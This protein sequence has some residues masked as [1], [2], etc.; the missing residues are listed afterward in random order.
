MKILAKT[1]SI[2]HEEWLKYRTQGIGGSDVSVIAGINPFKSVYQLWLE[3]IGQ[4]DIEEDDTEYTHFGR[5]L[6][7]I[8]RKEFINRTGMKVRQ[9]HMILQSEEYPF[10]IANLDGTIN[11]N[12]E[13]AIFEA[14]AVSAFKQEIWEVGIPSSYILQIQ[15]YMAVTGAKKAYIA[16]IVG[17]NHFYYHM[18]ERD[19]EMIEKIILMEKYFWE[20]NVLKGIE[21]VLDGSEATTN[22]IN[23]KFNHSN[24]ETII[25]PEEAIF[26][27]EEYERL[28]K[29]I[30]EIEV[31]KNAVGNQLKNYLKEAETGIIGNRKI[32]WKQIS[33][34]FIDTKRLK[35]EKPDIYNDYLTQSQYRRLLI[36]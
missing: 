13:L 10:M 34:S 6:E 7:P 19:E 5:L 16:A 21:P 24:G 14:K 9:K 28:S 15:H 1:K 18:L 29:Q 36:V 35:S 12:G 8:V 4:T 11:D 17:G 3:K 23:R 20:E 2:N 33:K 30:K 32:L 25:L 31:A 27:C 22:Y 26:I